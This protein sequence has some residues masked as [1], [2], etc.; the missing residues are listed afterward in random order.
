MFKHFLLTEL[1]KKRLNEVANYR[2]SGAT[3]QS[4]TALILSAFKKLL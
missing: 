2:L 1:A 3:I 4:L